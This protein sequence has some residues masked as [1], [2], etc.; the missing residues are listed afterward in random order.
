MSR[1]KASPE[2]IG[3][4]EYNPYDPRKTAAI[5]LAAIAIFGTSISFLFTKLAPMVDSE[6]TDYLNNRKKAVQVEPT[7]TPSP[8]PTG[9]PGIDIDSLNKDLP[10]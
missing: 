4:R 3:T 10:R 9:V 6:V 7:A 5:C 1:Y 2:P 8:T